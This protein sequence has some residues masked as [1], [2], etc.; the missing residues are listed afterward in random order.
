ME[1]QRSED[2]STKLQR[3]AKLAQ[4]DPDRVFT[5]L[6]HWIDEAWMKEAYRR[7]RKD[8]A[9]G[10][11]GQTSKEYARQL[12]EN[13][14]SLVDRFRSGQ[15]RAPAVRRARIPKPAGGHRAIGI[16]TFEDKL[17]QR[18]VTMLLSAI[19]E[20]DFCDCSYGARPKRSAHQALEALRN[21]LME[22]HGG[23]V[24]E[25]D[26]RGFFD[27]ID[28]GQLRTMM[29]QRVGDGVLRRTINKWLKAGVLDD[30]T[31]RRSS[32]G[33]P[34]GGVISPLLA[35]IYLH[36]VIDTW[37][38]RDVK[39]RLRGQAT[40]VRY[41]DDFVMV[42]ATQEDAERVMKVLPK[43]LARYG[44]EI[45]PDKTRL[46]QYRQPPKNRGS[47]PRPRTFD[48]LGFTH[49]WGQSRKGNWVIKRKTARDR[50][51]RAMRTINDWC[52]K[53]R[54]WS[55]AEQQ[56]MLSAKLRG[57]YGYYGITA[58]ARA[59]TRFHTGVLRAWRKWLHRRSGRA[60]MTWERFQNLLLHY[61]LPK[62]RLVHR[63]VVP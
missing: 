32:R 59:L 38:A 60:K 58:N 2:V 39:P 5:S 4:Q 6:S 36:E 8:G 30:Q 57:H 49:Y 27:A 18:A 52:R 17:L 12:D 50:F 22:M 3:I 1:T 13:V 20:Q 28:H 37:F 21:A 61:P 47:G 43:R 55:L 16:P 62:P 44:L 51:A 33:T 19:Y 48:F 35:N 25:V 46:L 40:M 63:Y 54:H 29:D 31:W 14:L 26:I 11:D 9:V 15:Y 45:H 56:R 34:Q 42:F 10:I 53:H 41:I 23:W 24:L 7:T